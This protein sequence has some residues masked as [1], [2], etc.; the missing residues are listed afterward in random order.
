MGG[1]R[2]LD[3]PP[4]PV[5]VILF[6]SSEKEDTDR[7]RGVRVLGLPAHVRFCLS[8]CRASPLAQGGEP[9]PACRPRLVRW[10]S[11][12]MSLHTRTRLPDVHRGPASHQILFPELGPCHHGAHCWW[13]WR[14]ELREIS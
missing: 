1:S 5:S 7:R 11:V 8:S 4:H 9:R 14:Q 2:S 10:L 13:G 6:C 3:P 12:L